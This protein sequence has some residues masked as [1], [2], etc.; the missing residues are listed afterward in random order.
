[1]R[2]RSY[3]CLCKGE[4]KTVVVFPAGDECC[5]LYTPVFLVVYV[6]LGVCM[7]FRPVLGSEY[8]RGGWMNGGTVRRDRGQGCYRWFDGACPRRCEFFLF[9]SVGSFLAG[10]PP[11]VYYV[12]SSRR[13][14][15]SS[16]PDWFHVLCS[17]SCTYVFI[18]GI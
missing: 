12:F 18:P 9:V 17:V 10:S 5:R 15:I 4:I 3:G 13:L 2:R 1:M 14:P 7:I 8:V 16:P 11:R 6:D